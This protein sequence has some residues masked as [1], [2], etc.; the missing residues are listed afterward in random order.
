MVI[1][2]CSQLDLFNNRNVFL[3]PILQDARVHP[4]A[5]SI[6]GF[7]LVDVDTKQTFSLSVAHPEAIFQYADKS[8]SFLN[9][10]TVY[11]YD[12][13]VLSYCG[14]SVDGFL[15]AELQYYLSFNQPYS[16]ENPPIVQ[17]YNRA[18]PNCNLIGGLI[19]LQKH[20][21]IALELFEKA[22]VQQKQVG[23]DFYQH[24]LVPA[25]F[26]IEKNGLQ[27]DVALFEQRFGQTNARV[28]DKCYTHYNF[29]TITGRPSNRFGGVNFA[30]LN[31]EDQTR[32]C[33]ISRF[34]ED[35][36]LV[37]IDFNAYH[38]RLIASL[39]GYDFGSS[40]AYEQLAKQ[41]LNKTNPSSSD[42]KLIKEA[43]FR[44]IYGGIQ[45]QFLSIPFFFA[46]NELSEELWRVFTRQGYIESIL[47]GRRLYSR[48]HVDI[49]RNTLFN[50]F[51]QMHETEMN[52]LVLN[53]IHKELSQLKSVPILYTYD[54]I[55]FDV[56]KEDQQY[57]VE[58]VLPSCI[59][60]HKF[61][62]KIKSGSVYKDLMVC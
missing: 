3:Y 38:P 30:A 43:T 41:Y 45:Q 10:C 58:Q 27:I 33:F 55:L 13:Q 59:D 8:L 29:F 2:N 56:H 61:P 42:V 51:I 34:G 52:V 44:Q 48:N 4:V 28:A 60:Y 17:H 25:F 47:S 49:D 62:V 16:F 24:Q 35:G 37:E 19:G 1:D 15:D 23:L 18:Y 20:E 6:L 36:C 53:K 57:L 9:S 50:Y 31:K 39:I 12:T 14:Y 26:G 54:S 7:V 40:S 46:A 11:S 21:Q 32:E 5:A 22:F